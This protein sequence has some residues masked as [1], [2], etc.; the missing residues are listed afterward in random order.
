M[1]LIKKVFS[2]DDSN[3]DCWVYI[4]CN[5]NGAEE[6]W[7]K[8]KDVVSFLGYKNPR[9]A[10]LKNVHSFWRKTWSE[11][12]SSEG[13]STQCIRQDE[14]LCDTDALPSRWQSHTIFIS[15]PGLYALVTHSKKPE[16][17]KFTR[18]IYEDVLPSL[19]RDL[20]GDYIQ[21][22]RDND[23]LQRLTLDGLRGFVYL[24][25]T[26]TYKET[27]IYKIGFTSNLRH[28]LDGLNAV[29]LPNDEFEFVETWEVA[30]CRRAE[31]HVFATLAERRKHKEFFEFDSRESAIS[32]I[33]D[34]IKSHS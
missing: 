11:L 30:D 4:S 33:D 2:F 5:I 12:A 19:R 9:D 17:V 7:F 27:G 8:A 15:E 22:H 3:F 31:K 25:T 20:L 1:S 32:L 21:K 16:A 29:R 18:W 10:I 23:E 34:A 24:A 26:P 6:Y 13:V 28:R 14:M